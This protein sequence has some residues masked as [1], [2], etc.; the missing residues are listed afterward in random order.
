MSTARYKTGQEAP[1]TDNYRFDGF[2]DGTTSC[3]PTADESFIPLK[4]GDKFPPIRSCNAA[5]W[6]VKA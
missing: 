5:A 4:K 3:R 2:A 1:S 6:W